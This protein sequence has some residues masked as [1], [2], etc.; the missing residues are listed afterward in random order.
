MLS[1]NEISGYFL[2]QYSDFR[3]QNGQAV[4][5]NSHSNC[6]HKSLL[7]Y[8]TDFCTQSCNNFPWAVLKT[9]VCNFKQESQ[10]CTLEKKQTAIGLCNP[11]LK[12]K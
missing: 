4:P 9:W 5:P 1:W 8:S 2:S 6:H 7:S 11:I 10:S 3:V 12:I